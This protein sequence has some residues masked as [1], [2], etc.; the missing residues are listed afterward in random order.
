MKKH[1][2]GALL[3]TIYRNEVYI[4]LGKENNLWFPFKGVKKKDETHEEA[5]KRE[6]YEETYG[7]VIVDTIDL[8]CKF[9]T[10]RKH[11]H[12]GICE[13]PYETLFV[14]N[15]NKKLLINKSNHKDIK[16]F[17]EK[18]AIRIFP[19]SKILNYKFHYITEIPIKHYYTYLLSINN[20]I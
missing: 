16:D 2:C 18:S 3:Y 20:K 14:I 8:A 11:Y 13:V 5:A 1:S 12:I 17:L 4:I 6:I 10:N 19:L 9:T 15:N 7:T